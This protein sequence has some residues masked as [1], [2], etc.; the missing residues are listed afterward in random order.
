MSLPA[1]RGKMVR[2]PSSSRS[3]DSVQFTSGSRNRQ[4]KSG[5]RTSDVDARSRSSWFPALVRDGDEGGNGAQ[6][7]VEHNVVLPSGRQGFGTVHHVAFR[8][9]D[10]AA[11]QEWIE[12][13][14]QLR[15]N[16]SGY[17]DRFFFE[18]SMPVSRAVFCSNGQRMVLV[19]WVTSRTKRSGRNCRY[20]HSSSR[21]ENRSNKWSVRSIRSGALGKSKKN[22][23]KRTLR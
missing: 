3:R 5:T 14:Q 22:T 10:T 13:M 4:F 15:F 17:V 21:N 6:V 9:E 20:H 1:H 2:Y 12:R 18:S 23:F 11:L 19:S 7:I 8:V 16:T